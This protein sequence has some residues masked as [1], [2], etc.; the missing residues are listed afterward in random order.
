[1]ICKTCR[2]AADARAPRTAHCADPKCMCGHRADRYDTT[3][4]EK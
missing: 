3:A 1:M 4:K 2:D